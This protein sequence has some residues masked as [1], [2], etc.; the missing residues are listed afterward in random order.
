MQT[1]SFMCLSPLAKPTFHWRYVVN[2]HLCRN[3]IQTLRSLYCDLVYF[4]FLKSHPFHRWLPGLPSP[5]RG[6]EVSWQG[7]DPCV[8]TEPEPNRPPRD[9]PGECWWAP[10]KCGAQVVMWAGQKSSCD[11]L[12]APWLGRG[13]AHSSRASL[14]C[15]DWGSR[16]VWIQTLTLLK[17]LML[18]NVPGLPGA[19]VAMLTI[20]ILYHALI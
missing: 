19:H 1:N 4:R 3:L 10:T 16:G 7:K 14:G 6:R 2:H 9:H 18:H 11:C 5:G 12:G 20:T 15:W 17:Y 8:H 13:R